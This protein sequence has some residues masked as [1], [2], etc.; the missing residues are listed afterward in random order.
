MN[1]V[2]YPGGQPYAPP[3]ELTEEELEEVLQFLEEMKK[4]GGEGRRREM[5]TDAKIAELEKQ[6]CDL[7]KHFDEMAYEIEVEL[8][9]DSLNNVN[10]LKIIRNAAEM[11]VCQRR[12][13]Y[14]SVSAG[15]LI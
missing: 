13:A 5:K 6:I 14:L 3:H 8:R 12:H 1:N 4:K 10:T 2:F 15:M 9:K 11:A 7:E